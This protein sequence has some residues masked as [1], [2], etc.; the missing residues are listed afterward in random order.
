MTEINI[1]M[2]VPEEFK[3]KLELALTKA[4]SKFSR[5]LEFAL[6]DEILSKSKL[7]DKQVNQLSDDLKINV[8]KKPRLNV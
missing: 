1:K 3:E 7:T 2:N 8:A 4:V 5:E 6:A